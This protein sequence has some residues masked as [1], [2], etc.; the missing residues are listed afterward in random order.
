MPIFFECLLYF[1]AFGGIFALFASIASLIFWLLRT[2]WL[3]GLEPE[4]DAVKSKQARLVNLDH[5]KRAGQ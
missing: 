5:L 3:W 4:T 2:L 1:I